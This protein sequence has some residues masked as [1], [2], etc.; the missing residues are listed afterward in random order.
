MSMNI[1]CIVLQFDYESHF[2]FPLIRIAK[3]FN[4]FFWNNQLFP[5]L[6]TYNRFWCDISI[7]FI[8]WINSWIFRTIFFIQGDD[9]ID[10]FKQY[11]I[12]HHTKYFK[13]VVLLEKCPE[14]IRSKVKSYFLEKFKRL[15]FRNRLIFFD[16][17]FIFSLD[18]NKIT[19][20]RNLNHFRNYFF[21]VENMWIRNWVR[22]LEIFLPK[23]L[24]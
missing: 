5:C 17:F 7:G 12:C 11:R 2:S 19:I 6:Y 4:A 23:F 21:G 10:A 22:F 13:T 3:A 18:I 20:V 9:E 16:S 15:P 24:K 14:Y 1:I 8:E